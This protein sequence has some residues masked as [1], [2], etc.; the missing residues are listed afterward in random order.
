MTEEEKIFDNIMEKKI[1]LSGQELNYDGK[2]KRNCLQGLF[3]AQE[4]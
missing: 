2:E 1:N 4:V 3:H